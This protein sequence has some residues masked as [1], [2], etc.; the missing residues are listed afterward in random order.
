MS[1]TFQPD[2]NGNWDAPSTLPVVWARHPTSGRLQRTKEVDSQGHLVAT[3]TFVPLV[4]CFDDDDVSMEDLDPPKP[5]SNPEPM[6]QHPPL[7]RVWSDLFSDSSDDESEFSIPWGT[8]LWDLD[9][10][11]EDNCTGVMIV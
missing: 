4:V 8:K 3:N 10:V 6:P 5:S 11:S 2:S 1:T 9:R 7:P